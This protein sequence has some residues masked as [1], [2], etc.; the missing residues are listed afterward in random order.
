MVWVL[1]TIACIYLAIKFRTFRYGFAGIV[2]LLAVTIT[3]Y[4]AREHENEESSKHLVRP[5]QLVFTDLRLGPASYGYVLTGRV[6]NNSQFTVFGV[7][8]KV[9][10]LDCDEQLHCDVVGEEET[11]NVCPLLPTVTPRSRGSL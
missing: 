8:A 5:D 2:G 11:F 10:I 4:F 9:R 1:V 6:R 3:I 7:K